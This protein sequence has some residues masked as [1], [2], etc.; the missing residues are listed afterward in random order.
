MNELSN[1]ADWCDDRAAGARLK[2]FETGA[3]RGVSVHHVYRFMADVV[4]SYEAERVGARKV[5]LV[6]WL[7]P[8]VSVEVYINGDWPTQEGIG[9]MMEML[10][11]VS[12]TLERRADRKAVESAKALD[13]ASVAVSADR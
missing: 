3:L 10:K 12:E 11:L 13:S 5:L 7:D 1:L 9:T 6:S 2:T 4:R 8:G